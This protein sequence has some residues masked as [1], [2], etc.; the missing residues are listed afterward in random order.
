MHEALENSVS[1]YLY[2]DGRFLQVSG[3]KFA[4]D[5]SKPSGSRVD[6]YLITVQDEYLSLNKVK[7]FQHFLIFE[8]KFKF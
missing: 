6:P 2:Q 8:F 5:P 3:V 7:Y 4:F 1:M